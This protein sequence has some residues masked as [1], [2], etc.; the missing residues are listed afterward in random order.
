MLYEYNSYL[1]R[2]RIVTTWSPSVYSN[3]TSYSRTLFCIIKRIYDDN[4]YNIVTSEL[5]RSTYTRRLLLSVVDTISHDVLYSP[6]NAPIG[7]FQCARP[8]PSS[9]PENTPGR[10]TPPPAPLRRPTADDEFSNMTNLYGFP[11]RNEK[12]AAAHGFLPY[13][14]PEIIASVH[15]RRTAFVN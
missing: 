1:R 7:V 3:I 15:T 13:A 10:T 4:Y 14:R 5:N 6:H 11:F 9:P 2:V 8:R 12:S